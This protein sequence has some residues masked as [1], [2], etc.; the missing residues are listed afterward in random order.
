MTL[1]ITED[2]QALHDTARRWVEPAACRRPPGRTLDAPD[3][4]LPAVLGRAGRAGLARPPR[5]RGARRPGL[6]P[7]RAGRGARGAGPG[8]ARPAVPAHC[9]GRGRRRPLADD[10]RERRSCRGWSTARRPAAVAFALGRRRPPVDRRLGAAHR[11]DRR[12]RRRPTAGGVA[13]R[14]HGVEVDAL[15]ASTRPGA[16]PRCGSTG[17][18]DVHRL[19]AEPRPASCRDLAAVLLAAER[20]AARPGAST[21]RRPTPRCA[22]SS[23]GPSASS[24]RSSTAA[25]TCSSPSSRPGR[26][27]GTPPA[28]GDDDEAPLAAAVAGALAPD[29]LAALRQGLHPGARRHRLHLG[30]RR[31]PLPAPGDGHPPALGGAEAWHGRVVER[32]SGGA[33]RSMPSSCRAEAEALPRRGPGLPRRR[34]DATTGTERAPASPTR[35]LPRAQLARRRGVATPAPIEQLVI[36]EE[37][38]GRTSAG[39][40][41]RSAPGCCRR[42]SP[43]AARAAGAVDAADAAR[44]AQLV[45]DVQRAG[46]RLATSLARHQGGAGRRRLVAHRPEGVDDD[47]PHR[48]LGHLP[49]PHQPGRAEARR[50]HVL[51]RRHDARRAST[52]ARCA[53]S[54][55]PRCST[56]SSST[57]CSCPT[58]ASSA[59]ST[60][61][62]RWPAPPSPT[63][64]SR[65]AAASSFGPGVE[66][67]LG[68]ARPTAASPVVVDGV[69]ALLAEATRSPPWA[70][71]R[72]CGP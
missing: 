15:Q 18:P 31:P 63:S 68:Q 10:A 57:T 8:R 41:L 9:P 54:P 24:R 13:D 38:A 52:S 37:F 17:E 56:R 4:A 58:T 20:R 61:A 46:R 2:H 7:G 28:G 70:C 1:G 47:G 60:T 32:A 65:W 39:R 64:G 34:S 67:L 72:R 59:R 49:G 11:G 35:G 50:H 33:R 71:A 66:A 48:R 44:R 43:T 27:R 23:A 36:D 69:G 21:P 16:W 3:D 62:G 14:R 6:R 53:S 29:G 25:P 30:A 51:P 26:R 5:A 40:H 19:G 45:P 42:S 55:A 22:S 12:G